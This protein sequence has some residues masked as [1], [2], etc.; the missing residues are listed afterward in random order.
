MRKS[1]KM[2]ESITVKVWRVI[3]PL[4]IYLFVSVAIQMAFVMVLSFMYTANLDVYTA[5]KVEDIANKVEQQVYANSS[6]LSIASAAVCIPVLTFF[7]RTDMKKKNEKYTKF[8]P[9]FYLVII[10]MG[11]AGCFGFSNLVDIMKISEVFKTYTEEVEGLLYGTGFIQGLIANAILAPI[12]EELLFRGLVY[13]RAQSLMKSFA[14]SAIVT[15]LIFAFMHGNMVQG[16]YAFM[17]GMILCFV[18]DKTHTILA[19]VIFHMSANMFACF[20]TEY[21]FLDKMYSSDSAFIISTVVLL[22]VL[23]ICGKFLDKKLNV[24]KM[25]E[26]MENV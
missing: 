7:F 2:E 21:R 9:L 16:V 14:G 4:L 22:A 3:Y 23:V 8:N 13:N 12:L 17:V 25:E 15:S 20:A 6:Y 1:E 11:I 5:E 19:P 18:Y 24:K 26:G 10:V